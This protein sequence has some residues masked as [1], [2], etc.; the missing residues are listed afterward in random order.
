MRSG[1]DRKARTDNPIMLVKIGQTRLSHRPRKSGE[2]RNPLEYQF[3]LLMAG[4]VPERTSA[5]RGNRQS[6]FVRQADRNVSDPE[7]E[8]V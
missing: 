2:E 5:N 4:I 7:A 8:A 6:G 3:S 1:L